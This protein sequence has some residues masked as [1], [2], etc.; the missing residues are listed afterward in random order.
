MI[1]ALI[2]EFLI[3]L[4]LF[5]FV[6]AVLRNLF[7]GARRSAPRPSPSAT[8]PPPAHAGGVLHKD[9]VC[10]TYVSSDS[11][12]TGGI[13]GQTLYFCSQE[14]KDKYQFRGQAT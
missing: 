8:P 2:R 4:L 9:P 10:G 6:R 7:A 5:L 1:S 14:C 13:N 12:I 3:P 11:A